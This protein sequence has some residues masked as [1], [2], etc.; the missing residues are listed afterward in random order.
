MPW[1]AW[2]EVP[3]RADGTPDTTALG[4][5]PAAS[6]VYAIAGKH[7]NGMYNTQYVGRSR[8]SVR[9]RL[10]RHLAGDGNTVIGMQLSLRK[11]LPMLQTS[12]WV[13]YLE[14]K[15]PSIVEAV[16]LDTKKLPICNLIRARLPAEVAEALVWKSKLED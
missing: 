15:E 7:Q 6:G 4:K 3:L 16:Y 10:R 2:I 13:A 14:T 1:S 12:F 11:K 5:V 8:R 9:E